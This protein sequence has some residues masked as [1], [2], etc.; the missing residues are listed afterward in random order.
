MHPD[1]PEAGLRLEEL[2]AGQPVD[3][4][5]LVRRLKK[6]AEE[7]GL[8]FGD[9]KKTYNSRLAQ[10]LGAWAETQGH[11]DVFHV[12]AFQAYFGLGENIAR[13]PVLLDIAEKAGLV[14]EAAAKIL[15]ER[16]FRKK[17]DTD[18]MRAKD[19]NITVVPTLVCNQDRLAG[20]RP[21]EDIKIMIVKNGAIE[22]KPV[23]S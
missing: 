18:W 21:Y 15:S 5:E 8:P 6:K 20:A 17:V 14:P 13:V 12:T 11:G 16:T 22:K 1:T 10:E 3:V 19:L 2:F 23:K 4:A 7:V 9:R